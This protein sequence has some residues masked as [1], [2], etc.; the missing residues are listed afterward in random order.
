MSGGR[1]HI[2]GAGHGEFRHVDGGGLRHRHVLIAVY[3]VGVPAFGVD[4]VFG[5]F[6]VLEVD[7]IVY[8]EVYLVVDFFLVGKEVAVLA[9]VLSGETIV[10]RGYR[11]GGCK[12]KCCKKYFD[13]R[14]IHDCV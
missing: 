5:L 10:L 7:I 14:Q 8:G 2:S 11:R 6:F 12:K 13:F 9:G 4:I 1:S 3:H